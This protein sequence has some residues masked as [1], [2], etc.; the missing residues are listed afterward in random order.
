MAGLSGQQPHAGALDAV[1]RIVESETEPDEVL[2]RVVAVLHERLHAYSAV[3][4]YFVEEDELLLG[5]W[6]GSGPAGAERL[7]GLSPV[8]GGADSTRVGPAWV[9]VPVVYRGQL[10]ALLAVDGHTAEPFG[11]ADRALLER[12]AELIAAHCLVGWDTGGVPWSEVT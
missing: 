2:R 9:D 8:E 5:P 7:G 1:E 4:L 6:S 10:V 12:V 11:D 3:A